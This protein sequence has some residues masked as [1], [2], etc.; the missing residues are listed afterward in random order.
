MNERD[1]QDAVTVPVALDLV[2]M[3]SVNFRQLRDADDYIGMAAVRSSSIE[4]DQIDLQSAREGIPSVAD[5]ALIFPLDEMVGHPDLL[6]ATANEQIIGYAHVCWRWTEITGDRVYLHLGYVHPKW[7]G[8]GVGSVMLE[9]SRQRIREIAAVDRPEGMM[10]FASN[11][12]STEVEASSLLQDNG[13][14]VVR[15]LTDMVIDLRA[16]ITTPPLPDGIELRT[17]DPAHYRT[18]YDAYKD[19]V[20]PMWTTTQVS[21]ADFCE[22]VAEN[23]EDEGFDPSLC[24]VAWVGDEVVGYVLGRTKLG[25][26]VLGEVG[27]RRR[28]QRRGVGRALLAGSLK[29]FQQG[30]LAK[31]RLF[32]DASD[33]QGARSLYEQLGFQEAKQHMLYRQAFNQ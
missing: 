19:A 23:F 9:W 30:G 1:T 21:E 33:G 13:Y 12:S 3:P 4:H 27:V 31:T 32:T 11:A 16:P 6:I 8:H 26:G 14:T 7:R 20:S 22:F 10:T 15:T 29:V 25:V 24:L 2:G 28:W 17:I 5:L 18:I